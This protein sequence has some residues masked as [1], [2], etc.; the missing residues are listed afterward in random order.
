MG[1]VDSQAFEIRV[2]KQNKTQ[3]QTLTHTPQKLKKQLHKT[4]THTIS[5]LVLS[6]QPGFLPISFVVPPFPAS[7]KNGDD[8]T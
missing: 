3:K 1:P 4:Q 6:F 2:L 7:R 8:S 5:H